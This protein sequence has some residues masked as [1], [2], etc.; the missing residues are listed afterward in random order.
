MD[1]LRFNDFESL[2]VRPKEGRAL[3]VGSCVYPGRVDRRL[4]YSDVLGV[5]MLPGEGVDHVHNMEDPLPSFMGW[6]DHVECLSVLEHSRRPWLVAQS[7]EDAMSPGATLFVSVPFIWRVHAYPSDYWRFTIEGV[8]NLFPRIDFKQ[9]LFA[10]SELS[11][12]V[13]IA[14]IQ[15]AERLY[16]ER[17]EVYGFGVRT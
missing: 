3:I 12:D 6:F 17:T 4:Q 5:D 11:G 1:S 13:S 9:L 7:I 8:R 10:H 2:H 15:Q 14:S 16:M